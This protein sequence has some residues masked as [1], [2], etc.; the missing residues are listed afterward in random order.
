MQTHATTI[1]ATYLNTLYSWT[2]LIRGIS[3]GKHRSTQLIDAVGAK[4]NDTK[5]IDYGSSV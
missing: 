5:I 2:I 1:Y 4:F 3:I